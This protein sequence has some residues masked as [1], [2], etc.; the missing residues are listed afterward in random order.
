[1]NSFDPTIDKFLN[2]EFDPNKLK[3]QKRLT[4]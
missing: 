3:H 2:Y 4:H 1:M